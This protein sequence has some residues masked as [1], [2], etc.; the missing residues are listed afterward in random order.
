MLFF[1]FIPVDSKNCSG[2]TTSFLFYSKF[3]SY[4]FWAW[5]CHLT[6][7]FSSFL[8]SFYLIFL[9][10][11]YLKYKFPKN[12]SDSLYNKYLGIF[13][14]LIFIRNIIIAM[15]NFQLEIL[16][17]FFWR[18]LHVWDWYPH[19]FRE[20]NSDNGNDGKAQQLQFLIE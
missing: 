16:Q 8:A 15:S 2:G 5:A 14:T 1:L 11:Q 12:N 13:M 6:L 9:Y 20:Y 17:C 18:R 4:F 7:S 19:F 10:L 3:V